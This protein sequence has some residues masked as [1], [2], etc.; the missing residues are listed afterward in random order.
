MK[1]ILEYLSWFVNEFLGTFVYL[2]HKYRPSRWS[3]CPTTMLNEFFMHITR[4][5]QF[6]AFALPF[7]HHPPLNGTKI[8]H[9]CASAHRCGNSASYLV[10]VSS[11]NVRSPNSWIGRA[12]PT[13]ACLSCAI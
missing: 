4:V 7:T 13:Y 3:Y 10:S 1:F 9:L 6:S 2:M 12:F 5:L 11:V 8:P